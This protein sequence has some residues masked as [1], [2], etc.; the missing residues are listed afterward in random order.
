M[1]FSIPQGLVQGAFP[2]TAY[3]STIQAV[4]KE[5]LTLNGFADDHLLRRPVV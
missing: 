3:A 2:F 4:I 1:E 5:D